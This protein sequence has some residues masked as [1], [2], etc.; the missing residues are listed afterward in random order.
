MALKPSK[1]VMGIMLGINRL[2]GLLMLQK[3]TAAKGAHMVV[4]DGKSSSP[5]SPQTDINEATHQL[6]R[7]QHALK[8]DEE[9]QGSLI[10][11]ELELSIG[12]SEVRPS[13]TIESVLLRVDKR[14]YESKALGKNR[15]TSS[16]GLSNNSC[17]LSVSEWS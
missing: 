4:G 6:K 5:F 14:M 2:N 8:Y 7:I 11:I 10:S 9:S 12:L 3:L 13:D 16:K 15:I 17:C 1:M